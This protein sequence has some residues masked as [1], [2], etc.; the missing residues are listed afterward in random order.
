MPDSYMRAESRGS[1]NLP[2]RGPRIP[3]GQPQSRRPSAHSPSRPAGARCLAPRPAPAGLS[4]GS[5]RPPH[6]PTATP[7]ARSKPTPTAA[8]P[9]EE[10][11]PSLAEGDAAQVHIT[12]QSGRGS[13]SARFPRF[14]PSWKQYRGQRPSGPQGAWAPSPGRGHAGESH[15]APPGAHGASGNPGVERVKQGEDLALRSPA[16]SPPPPRPSARIPTLT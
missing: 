8:R 9:L 5:V 12:S 4:Q 10:Q 3:R 7:R 6:T 2:G 15:A 14:T 1:A 16:A 13:S 11:T